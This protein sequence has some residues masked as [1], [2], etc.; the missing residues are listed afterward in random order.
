MPFEVGDAVIHRSDRKPRQMVVAGRAFKELPP[1]C[2]HNE[3]AN[4]GHVPDGSYYCT[5]I[6]GAKKGAD[7]F[8]EEELELQPS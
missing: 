3:L 1:S 8:V 4:V 2:T 5:W 7:Y 6:A